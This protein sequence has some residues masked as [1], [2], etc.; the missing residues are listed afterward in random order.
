MR[1]WRR[2]TCRATASRRSRGAWWQRR[3]SCPKTRTPGSRTRSLLTASAT[4]IS[5]RSISAWRR[6]RTRR[7]STK[8]WRWSRPCAKPTSALQTPTARACVTPVDDGR[9][10][11]GLG[12]SPFDGEGTPTREIVVM[13]R[14]VLRTFV[15]DVYWGR[16][17]GMTSTGNASGGGGIAANN[18]YLAPGSGTLD[19]LVAATERGVLVL[20]TIGF[21]TELASGT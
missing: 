13:D 14:G 15:S 1:R 19:D 3:R 9:L 8:R 4:T 18:F 5:A 2:P 11:G 12:T 21:A 10:R 17:L 20:D 16:R 7:R 6:A